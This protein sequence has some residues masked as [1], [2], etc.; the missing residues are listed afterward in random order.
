MN[1]IKLARLA[2]HVQRRYDIPAASVMALFDVSDLHS[3]HNMEKL[4]S[5]P[6]MMDVVLDQARGGDK[7]P[8][9]RRYFS[10]TKAQTKMH[11]ALD[12]LVALCNTK[13]LQC[14]L[15]LMDGVVDVLVSRL[16]E[17]KNNQAAL[18]ALNNLLNRR[19]NCKQITP[20][21]LE[22]I[23]ASLL[24]NIA[25]SST[26]QNT[27]CSLQCLIKLAQERTNRAIIVN[28]NPEIISILLK[29]RNG[30]EA[31]DVLALLACDPQNL[32]KMVFERND[33]LHLFVQECA[34]GRERAGHA[35]QFARTGTVHCACIDCHKR[36][37]QFWQATLSICA[38]ATA[39]VFPRTIGK[40][41]AT[42][43]IPHE[44]RRLTFHM[45]F[46]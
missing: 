29:L 34:L 35:L 20:H 16:Q 28:C 43:F 46:S 6:E 26:P 19:E 40:K 12:V 33:I 13:S 8:P 21:Q 22:R 2:D 45:L 30:D 17:K 25:P 39:R 4:F 36:E 5:F 18:T 31:C 37:L 42:R 44:L 15:F 10:R 32:Q 1:E 14:S 7:L 41:S 24:K 38:L 11:D 9:H 27:T 3:V 23:V